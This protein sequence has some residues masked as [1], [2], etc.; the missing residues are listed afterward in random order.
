VIST[1]NVDVYYAHQT[2]IH[3]QPGQ[4]VAAGQQ[5]GTVGDTG[6]TTGYHLHYE[7]RVDDQAIDPE[8]FMVARGIDLRELQ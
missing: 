5:I 4:V 3:V 6:N 2:S 8:P 1:G 7:I